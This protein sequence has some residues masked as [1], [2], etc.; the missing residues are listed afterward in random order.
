MAQNNGS[1]GQ[2]FA[3]EIVSSL[4]FNSPGLLAM[5]N[6]GPNTNDAQFFITAIDDAGTT[7]PISLADMPQFLNGNY[8]I[9]GQLVS[10]FDTFE[11]IMSTNVVA[12]PTFNGEVSQPV[13]A[14]TITSA[15]VITDTQNAVLR[16]TA[17]ASFNGN[18]ATITVTATNAAQQSAQQS[19][20]ATAVV[21]PPKLGTVTNL[22]TTKGVP[23]TLTLTS[24]PNDSSAGVFY[25]VVDPVS[26]GAPA[27]VTISINQQTGQ[28][29]LTPAAGFTG[30]I[31]LLAGVRAQSAAD[32][33]ANYD[34]QAFTLT[35]TTVPAAPTSLAV[36]PLST[37][38]AVRW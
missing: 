21:N 28:V 35:V 2:N 9:F 13:S 36:D 34:T 24:T 11:K 8:T 7:N 26:F 32:A 5:A 22:T 12:N 30:T 1:T 3:S 31:N 17:P 14:I 23:I 4:T 15:Q 10:G 18:S 16:V 38:G 29:T 27:N 25:T 33:Q 6:A 20:S 19:F 37:P